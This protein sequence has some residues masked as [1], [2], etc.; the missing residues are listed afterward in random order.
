MKLLIILLVSM[1]AFSG[2]EECIVKLF[3]NIEKTVSSSS[4]LS[5]D[6]EAVKQIESVIELMMQRSLD[7]SENTPEYFRFEE[8]MF[9]FFSKVSDD[10][11]LSRVF[12]L[13]SQDYRAFLA[14]YLIPKHSEQVIV[15]MIDAAEDVFD[16]ISL[17]VKYQIQQ[18]GEYTG[19]DKKTRI[20]KHVM[21]KMTRSGVLISEIEKHRYRFELPVYIQLLKNQRFGVRKPKNR[22][23]AMV[24]LVNPKTVT[25]EMIVSEVDPFRKWSLYVRYQLTQNGTYEGL[26]PETELG[27]IVTNSV[28]NNGLRVRKISEH[29]KKFDPEILRHIT[30]NIGTNGKVLSD[31]VRTQTDIHFIGPKALVTINQKNVTEEMIRKE[32]HVPRK[33]ALYVIY[34]IQL[35]GH[36]TGIKRQ[37]AL[38]KSVQNRMNVTDFK[39][40]DI[41]LYENRFDPEIYQLIVDNVR[42]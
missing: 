20:G 10:H 28:H 39:L 41:K 36:Y 6:S 17:Y 5:K 12:K 40:K 27:K 7:I 33:L 1:H 9:N 24:T 34:Q 16:K 14:R 13:L 18:N 32:P 21:N 26:Q 38:G 25:K 42:K 15:G 31:R 8:E 19:I 30:G 29:A 37:T 4:K 35:H 22:P 2:D 11:D 23:Y 3:I